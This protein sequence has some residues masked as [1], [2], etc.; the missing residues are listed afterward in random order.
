MANQFKGEV[1]LTHNS[2]NYTMV[3]DFNALCDFESQTGKDALVFLG[4]MENGQASASELRS[5]MWAGLRQR[6]PEM[7]LELAGAILGENVDT[8]TKAANLALSDSASGKGRRP[9]KAR[10]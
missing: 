8:I 2:Q 1:D 6:H 9:A 7:T 10:A 3:L 4:R 5:L